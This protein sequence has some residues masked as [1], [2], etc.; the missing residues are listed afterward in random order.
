MSEATKEALDIALQAHI[1]DE[2]DGGFMSSYNITAAYVTGELLDE[3]S[4]GYYNEYAHGQPYHVSLGLA[5]MQKRKLEIDLYAS[6]D[7]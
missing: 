6:D 7:E 5:V 4:T 2:C 3:D 1:A